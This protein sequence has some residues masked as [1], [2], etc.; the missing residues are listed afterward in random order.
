MARC[1]RSSTTARLGSPVER[2]GA[3]RVAQLLLQAAPLGDVGGHRDEAAEPAAFVLQ[4]LD[5][6]VDP[7]LAAVPGAQQQFVAHADAGRNGTPQPLARGGVVVLAVEQQRRELAARFIDTVAGGP[8]EGVVDPLD[9]AL[10]VGDDDQVVGARG[11]ERQ[12]RQLARLLRQP[13]HLPAHRTHRGFHHPERQY[14]QQEQRERDTAHE[15]LH[16]ALAACARGVLQRIGEHAGSL[17]RQVGLHLHGAGSGS[18][19]LALALIHVSKQH[20]AAVPQALTRG[21]PSLQG[22]GRRRVGLVGQLEL[23]VEQRLD[24]EGI[25][26]RPVQRFGQQ[27]GMHLRDLGTTPGQCR[28]PAHLL[29]EGALRSGN[30][31]DLG[32]G[33]AHALETLCVTRLEDGQRGDQRKRQVHR[34]AHAGVQRVLP[35]ALQRGLR[36]HAGRRARRGVAVGCRGTAAHGMGRGRL[37][38]HGT[39]VAIATTLFPA[40]RP[41]PGAN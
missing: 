19:R 13:C 34:P 9:A 21:L 18:H 3:C 32:V 1:R 30:A 4:R 16:L 6:G 24:Q 37:G 41:N 22:L 11:N 39:R 38:L 27:F 33:R 20:F 12:S 2:V 28:H 23:R 8:R 17:Q 35:R 15:Q 36:C 14:R 29:G 25:G 26:T 5:V 10:G 7:E 40:Y 31:D